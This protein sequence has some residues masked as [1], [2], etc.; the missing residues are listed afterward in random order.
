M[1]SG[2][3]V[4]LINHGLGDKLAVAHTDQLISSVISSDDGMN[5]I[6]GIYHCDCLRMC[7]YNYMCYQYIILI[8]YLLLVLCICLCLCVHACVSVCM[9]VCVCVCMY[10][11]VC[12]C[13]CNVYQC[14]YTSMSSDISAIQ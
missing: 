1:C 5:T 7:I 14:V 3:G 9:Y 12:V 8:H 11:C 10:V 6:V 13:L 2:K 4:W